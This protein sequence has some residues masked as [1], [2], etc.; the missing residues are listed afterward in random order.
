MGMFKRVLLAIAGVAAVAVVVPVLG[1]AGPPVANEHQSFTS[2]PYQTDLCG[3]EVT[4]VDRVVE[5]YSESA[6]GASIDNLNVTT[7]YTAANGKS[8]VSHQ[9]G[10]ATFGGLTDNGDGTLSGVVSV[11]GAS[12]QWKLP[13]GRVIANDVGNIAFAFTETASGEFLGFDV[14]KQAGQRELFCGA[15]ITALT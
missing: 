12:A 7:V 4:A 11:K 13:S 14:I 9:A 3:I 15:V 2:D 8:V 1:L 10:V 6:N 5:H